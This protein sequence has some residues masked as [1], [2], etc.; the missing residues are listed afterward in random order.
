MLIYLHKYPCTQLTYFI[1]DFL[2]FRNQLPRYFNQKNNISINFFM[3]EMHKF[4]TTVYKTVFFWMIF[5][6]IFSYTKIIHTYVLVLRVIIQFNVK[7]IF[8][9]RMIGKS[10]IMGRYGD[11]YIFQHYFMNIFRGAGDPF[12]SFYW[13]LLIGML[14]RT[15]LYAER[16][17]YFFLKIF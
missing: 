9:L 17:F 11:S 10:G 5:F 3:Q 16:I 14:F 4:S 12:C 1:N 7:S 2:C 6:S 15:T 13:Y 8:F